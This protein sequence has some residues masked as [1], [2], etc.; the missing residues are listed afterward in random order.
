MAGELKA[1]T[2]ATNGVTIK[3]FFTWCEQE[4][5]LVSNP[6]ARVNVPRADDVLIATFTPAQVAALFTATKRGRQPLRDAALLALLFD[7]GLRVRELAG[8]KLA[9]VVLQPTGSHLT[10]MGK[11]R[12]QRTVP[13]GPSA[14]M[15][16][17][18]Y[19]TRERPPTQV[20]QVFLAGGR[21]QGGPMSVRAVQNV[22]KR[23]GQ[24]AGIRG[25]RCSPH[26]C[27][28]TYAVSYLRA[29]GNIMSLSR[30]MGHS[31]VTITERY[32]RQFSAEDAARDGISPLDTLWK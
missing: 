9:D 31:S 20:P 2:V 6:A 16:L 24:Q 25:V 14:R 4:G 5:L 29:G 28:H 22:V 1:S 30:L 23:L 21:G 19:L 10:V 12:K 32:L 15:A 17:H 27:R 11:G 13:I 3:G 8:L 18:R 7:C 26:D